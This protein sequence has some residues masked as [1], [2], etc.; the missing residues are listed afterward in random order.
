MRE[1][2]GNLHFGGDPEADDGMF[3][4]CAFDLCRTADRS[5]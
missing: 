5:I 4:G 2:L 1:R 3:D